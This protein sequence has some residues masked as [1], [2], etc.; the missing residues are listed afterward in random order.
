MR[1]SNK[2]AKMGFCHR[3]SENRSEGLCVQ[4]FKKFREFCK[5]FGASAVLMSV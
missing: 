2:Q 4:E 5:S 1:E 3:T